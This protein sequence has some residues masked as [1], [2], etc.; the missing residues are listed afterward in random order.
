MFTHHRQTVFYSLALLLILLL[1]GYLR[2]HRVELTPGWFS[3]EGTHLAIA[4]HLREGQVQYF[5]LNQS[6][7]LVARL[8]LFELVLA[9]AVRVFGLSMTTLRTLTGLLG[10]VSVGLLYGVTSYTLNRRVALLAAFMLAIYPQAVLYSRFGF[11]YNLL[12]PLM[13]LVLPGLTRYRHTGRRRWLIL[14]AGCVGLGLTSDVMMGIVIVP[15]LL[16]SL[17]TRKRDVLWAGLLMALPFAI[18]AGIMLLTVPDAFLFDLRYTLTRLGGTS[19]LE[20]ARELALNYTILLSQDYWMIAGLI[21]LFL[22]PGRN[23]RVIALGLLLLPILLLGRTVALHNL[24]AYY[25]IPLLPLVA[26][27]AGQF[28]ER[29]FITIASAINTRWAAHALAALLILTPL[30]T[31]TWLTIDKVNHFYPTAIDPFLLD[32][33]TTRQT[34]HFINTHSQP[35]DLTI[36][37]PGVGWLLENHTADFQ[38]AAAAEGAITPHL[39]PNIPAD[40]WAFDPRYAQAKFVVVDPLW[41]TWGAVHIPAVANLLVEV[42]GWPLVYEAGAIRVYEN[43]SQTTGIPRSDAPRSEVVASG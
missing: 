33:E 28:A 32:A 20:Q 37:S 7:L 9:G 34:A 10:V 42:E 40:R 39:P 21:G 36:A 17:W 15:V 6:T 19:L 26:L 11:S 4:R 31:I 35:D 1:A 2:L 16:V 30:V 22:L 5:A 43:P 13:L 27:G 41:T 38:M 18:Y 14:A 24:S 29:A 12:A 8:P 3:D 25:T 23:L